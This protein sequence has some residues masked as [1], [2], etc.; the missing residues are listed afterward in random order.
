MSISPKNYRPL[1]IFTIV[2]LAL[3][4][5]CFAIVFS[6]TNKRI[7]EIR[8]IYQD[9]N[10]RVAECDENGDTSNT[11]LMEVVVNKNNGSYPAVGIYR[12]I[13]KFYYTF[14]DREKDPYPNRLLKILTTTNRSAMTETSEF[15]F[16]EKRNL[17]FYFEKNETE[18]RLYFASGNPIQILEGKKMIDVG[19]KSADQIRRQLSKQAARLAAIFQNGLEN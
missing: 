5:G 1:Q 7:E 4:F 3:G 9:V 19:S 15:L 14:G 6:Q 2:M 13:V 16:D 8:K 12:S 18:K 17:I 10:K 11:F